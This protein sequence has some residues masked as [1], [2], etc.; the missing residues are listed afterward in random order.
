MLLKRERFMH[1]ASKDLDFGKCNPGRSYICADEVGYSFSL[2]SYPSRNLLP[3]EVFIPCVHSDPR[4]QKTKK[5]MWGDKK[6]ETHTGS[7]S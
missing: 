4:P 6:A 5:K 2:F 3:S 7:I 1:E